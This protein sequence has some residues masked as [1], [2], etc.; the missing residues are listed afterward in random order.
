LESSS[1]R[2]DFPSRLT[3]I[4]AG[5]YVTGAISSSDAISGSSIQTSGNGI[6]LGNVGIGT[7]NPQFKL[8]VTRES[9]V[10]AHYNNQGPAVFEAAESQIQLISDDSGT[11]ASKL[12]LSNAPNTGDNKHW[13]IDHKGPSANNRFDI[14]YFTS[15]LSGNILAP[16]GVEKVTITTVGN[17]GIGTTNPGAKLEVTAPTSTAATFKLNAPSYQDLTIEVNSSTIDYKANSTSDMRFMFGGTE[18]VRF[19]DTGNVGIGTTNPGYKLDVNGSVSTAA[20]GSGGFYFGARG[21]ITQDASYNWLFSTNGVGNA[22]AIQSATGNVGIG[23]T[24]PGNRLSVQGV[25]GISG[26]VGGGATVPST[27]HVASSTLRLG[28]RGSVMTSDDSGLTTVGTYLCNNVFFRNASGNPGY[29]TTNPASAILLTDNLTIF[30]RAASGTADTDIT[31][32][33]SARID[34]SGNVGIGTTSPLTTLDVRG[35]IQGLNYTISDTGGS[36]QW[37]KFGVFTAPQNGHTIH[38]RAYIHAGYNASNDQDYYIDIFF[39]TSNNNSTNATGFA[40]NSWY[41]TRGFNQSNPT[42]KWKA[43]AAGINATSYELF[44]YLPI[45]TNASQYTVNIVN[46]GTWQ[47]TMNLGQS[48]P[49]AASSTVLHSTLGFNIPIGNVGIGTT[50]PIG[51]FDVAT[52]ATSQFARIRTTSSDGSTNVGLRIQDGTTGTT[53][54]DGIYLGRASAINYLWTY[55]NEPWVFATNNTER[56]RIPAAG[57]FQVVGAVSVGNATPV[58]SGAGVTFPSSQNASSNA[59]TLDDYE[60]GTWTPEFRVNNSTAGVTY[61]STYRYGFYTKVGNTVTI[62]GGFKLSNNGSSTGEVRIG[63]LP[64]NATDVNAYQHPGVGSTTI[65]LKATNKVWAIVVDTSH[66]FFRDMTAVN[67]DTPAYDTDFDDDTAI[68]FT[69]TYKA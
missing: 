56:A 55:E 11:H 41:Y 8:H 10:N 61:D 50:S 51:S 65:V 25:V 26:A 42:P 43:N 36:A 45:Y 40:G 20:A 14:S 53:D 22:V 66:L 7:T 16:V 23:T 35:P 2:I 39:K 37:V 33:E 27:A 38:I 15:S 63:G 34:A 19:D 64:F 30:R 49:G 54:N 17:V 32:T 58:T 21:N 62:H 5:L 28:L 13:M 6:L 24:S 60:E 9:V 52:S 68:I 57:G 29:L 59:N 4:E 18:R 67:A 31:F 46:S 48:D 3:H 1:I 44:L 69:V 12:V 47:N